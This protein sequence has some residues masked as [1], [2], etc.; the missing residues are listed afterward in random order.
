MRITQMIEIIERNIPVLRLETRTLPGTSDRVAVNLFQLRKYVTDVAKIPALHSKANATL[1]TM[2]FLIR[3]EEIRLTDTV[4][5]QIKSAVENLKT[6][7][8]MLIESLK[9]LEIPQDDGT[10]YFRIPKTLNLSSFSEDMDKISQSLDNILELGNAIEPIRFRGF[11]K[12]S[13]WIILGVGITVIAKTL[14][15]FKT[16]ISLADKNVRFEKSHLELQQAAADEEI[17]QKNRQ[18]ISEAMDAFYRGEARRIFEAFEK[19][20]TDPKNVE[21]FNRVI[22]SIKNLQSLFS[23]GA[24]VEIP[25]LPNTPA[26]AAELNK[27]IEETTNAIENTAKALLQIAAPTD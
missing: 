20:P 10:I 26:E 14:L 3:H 12:G 15:I 22:H 1:A 25:L 9:S 16:A 4:N 2:P 21:A 6:L 23:R 19:D 27:D 11:E 7:A 8:A 17:L 18:M 5:T 13:D 24:S